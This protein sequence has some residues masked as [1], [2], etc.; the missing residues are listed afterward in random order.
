[1]IIDGHTHAYSDDDLVALAAM[2]QLIDGTLPRDSPHK[3]QLFN[4]GRLDGLLTEERAAGV[5]RLVLLPVA[6]SPAKVHPLN[7]AAAEAARK[8][9]EVIAF[10]AL[11]PNSDW[12]QDLAEAIDLGLKGVK[13]HPLQQ[14]F[15]LIDPEARR[16][17]A[18]V[19]E[20]GLPVTCDTLHR[21]GLLATKPHLA[22]FVQSHGPF[23]P[24]P[25]QIAETAEALP[26][27][28]IIAAH[29]GSLYGWDELTPLYDRPNVYF[30]LAYVDRLLPP[31]RVRE[32]IDRKGADRII[33][34]TD[35][36]WRRVAPALAW[37]DRLDLAPADREKIMAANLLGLIKE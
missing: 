23:A 25:D 31:D 19:A 14:Q 1:M 34:G 5:D 9:P 20:A 15:K 4:N 7:L 27:L 13:L 24:N 28:T 36:P 37:V 18:A 11:H 3:W 26:E 33:W 21:S 2:L 12:P 10:A 32:I 30:D 35:A 29:L 8:H 22:G 16:M 17:L 6:T